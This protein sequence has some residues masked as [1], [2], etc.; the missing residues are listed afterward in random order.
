MHGKWNEKV[1]DITR[2]VNRL[3]KKIAL[4]KL[5]F[6]ICFVICLNLIFLNLYLCFDFCAY[7]SIR[8]ILS[9]II[10]SLNGLV[11]MLCL[12]GFLPWRYFYDIIFWSKDI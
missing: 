11:I 2:N 12:F 5:K 1:N 6:F 7:A 9:Y 8:G 10:L 3:F 4:L